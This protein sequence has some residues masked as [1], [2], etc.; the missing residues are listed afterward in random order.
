MTSPRRIDPRSAAVLAYLAHLPRW[1]LVI[2]VLAVMLGALFLSG[3]PG[4]LLMGAVTA[5]VGWLAWLAWPHL[6][7]SG[8]ALR[9]LIVA[10]LGVLAASKLF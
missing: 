5:V 2:T 6:P 10:V 7:P 3:I 8:R 4:A 1:A 9:A